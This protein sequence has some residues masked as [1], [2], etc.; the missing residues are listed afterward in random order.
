[1]NNIHND[2]III[3]MARI[4]IVLIFICFLFVSHVMAQ[5]EFGS[6]MSVEV[7][8]KILPGLNISLEEDFRLRDNLQTVDRFSTTVELS[9]RFNPF[10]KVGGAYNLINYNHPKKDWEVRHRYYFYAT[11]TYRI[12][13]F[14]L[15][16]RER[17]QSTYRVGVSETATRANPKL[18]LRSRL[19]VEYDIRKC[20]FEP[21]ASIEL[22]NTLNDPQKNELDRLRYTVGSKYKLT[23]KS[24][25]NLFYRYISFTDEEEN[26]SHMIGLGYSY[27]F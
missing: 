1:V 15:S 22:Y 23:K 19:Q 3:Q 4:K 18:Y 24:E 2:Y 14:T 5:D 25:F 9:Y 17:F 27:K 11:G 8:K 26:S 16:L 21:F 7:T 10:I 6:S 12:D 20:K 13:R